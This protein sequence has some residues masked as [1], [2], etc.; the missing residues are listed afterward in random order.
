MLR[1]SSSRGFTLIELMISVAVVAIL[2][3]VALASYKGQIRKS[4]R[5]AAAAYAMDVVGKQQQFLLDRRAYATSVTGATASNGLGLT[6]PADVSTYYTVAFNP[7]VDNT[8]FPLA[9]TLVLTPQGDQVKDT[10]GSMSIT[11]Q[12]V[13]TATG[14]GTCW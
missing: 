13:K 8:T 10:C 2:T 14:S 3:S 1:R 4:R 12:L 11:N 7:P 9:F 6:V 5:A